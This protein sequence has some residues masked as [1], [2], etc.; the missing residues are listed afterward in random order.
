LNC[1]HGVSLW[2]WPPAASATDGHLARAI[3]DEHQSKL[4]Q[5]EADAVA[6][7]AVPDLSPVHRPEANPAFDFPLA[8]LVYL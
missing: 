1:D 5:P 4:D 3:G 8:F 6:K 2:A 7:R